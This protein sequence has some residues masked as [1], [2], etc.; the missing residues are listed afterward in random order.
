MRIFSFRSHGKRGCFGA[1][2][3]QQRQKR[4]RN[5]SYKTPLSDRG[6]K[7]IRHY[8]ENLKPTLGL[9]ND[10]NRAALN[11]VVIT[12]LVRPR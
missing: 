2:G 6:K 1:S 5:A 7:A 4:Q 12:N 8:G 9:L 11:F 3:V 10:V